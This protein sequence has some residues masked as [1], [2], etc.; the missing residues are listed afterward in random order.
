MD[1]RSFSLNYEMN[2][3]IYEPGIAKELE[4]DFFNDQKDCVEFTLDGYQK[5]PKLVRFYDS[6]ARLTSPLI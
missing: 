3:I 4:T 5:Q 2:A 1:I 6:V